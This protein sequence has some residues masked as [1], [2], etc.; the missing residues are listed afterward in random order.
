MY[1]KIKNYYYN[2]GHSSPYGHRPA[3]KFS[4]TPPGQSGPG[5][6]WKQNLLYSM[7][8]MMQCRI[9]SIPVDPFYNVS[10]CCIIFNGVIKTN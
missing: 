6:Q 7:Y 3:G 2:R 1:Y 9:H 4:G 8:L 10:E 5:R